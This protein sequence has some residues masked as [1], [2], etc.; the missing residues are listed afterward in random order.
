M[1]VSDKGSS[2]GISLSTGVGGGMGLQH[3]AS[4]VAEWYTREEIQ[5]DIDTQ[6]SAIDNLKFSSNFVH[7]YKIINI[8]NL[9][10]II[11]TIAQV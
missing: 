11:I 1:D 4:R 5:N 3:T 6:S 7:T 8:T 2:D 9:R 10:K